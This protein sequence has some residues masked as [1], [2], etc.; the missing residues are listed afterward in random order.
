MDDELR[1]V[2][3]ALA[4]LALTVAAAATEPSSRKLAWTGVIWPTSP[5]GLRNSAVSG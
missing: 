1:D 5:I 4:A 3:L 2:E